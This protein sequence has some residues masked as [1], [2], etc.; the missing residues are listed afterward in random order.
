MSFYY[1]QNM[2]TYLDG[3]GLCFLPSR[4]VVSG[5]TERLECGVQLFERDTFLRWT[6]PVDVGLERLG[7][8]ERRSLDLP[9]GGLCDLDTLRGR[10][11]LSTYNKMSS[12][13]IAEFKIS[14]GTII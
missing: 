3:D 14:K 11:L 13:H 5:L 2:P 12:N 6:R 9:G 8:T 1:I 7:L 10:L 4:V